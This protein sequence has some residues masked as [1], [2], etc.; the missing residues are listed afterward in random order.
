MKHKK[1]FLIITILIIIFIWSIIIVKKNKE[2]YHQS[3][4]YEINDGNL[5]IMHEETPT[6]GD[7]KISNLNTGTLKYKSNSNS[8]YHDNQASATSACKN[9]CATGTYY[10]GK[11][12]KLG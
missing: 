3:K 7:Y 4:N 10:N 8:T 6:K 11:C 9:Y 1:A 5:S 12:Y 2:V